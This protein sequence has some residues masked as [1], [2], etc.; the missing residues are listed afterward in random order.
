MKKAV[1]SVLF[2]LLLLF[3]GCGKKDDVPAAPVPDENA[4]HESVVPD[5]PETPPN[6]DE[7]TDTQEKVLPDGITI[8]GFDVSKLSAE[9][10]YDKVINGLS[11][12]NL[13]F[14]MDGKT[15]VFSAVDLN[16][17]CDAGA[18]ASYINPAVEKGS[19]QGLVLPGISFDTTGARSLLHGVYDT[20]ARNAAQSYG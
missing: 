19:D 4:A 13:T 12:Y 5:A 1:R 3:S 8:L 6:E 11:E 20:S 16:L 7:N 9:D 15:V 17:G 10:A 2:L 18:L 14:T